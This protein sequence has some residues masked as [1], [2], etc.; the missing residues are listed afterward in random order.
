MH[1]IMQRTPAIL[2]NHDAN[3]WPEY[4]KMQAVKP[5]HAGIVV[6]RTSWR[7]PAIVLTMQGQ[8]WQ[9]K[10]FSNVELTS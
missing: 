1:S 10:C 3:V 8:Y 4:I 2:I 6:R 9:L 7:T 5:K